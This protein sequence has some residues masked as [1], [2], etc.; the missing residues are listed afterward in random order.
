MKTRLKLYLVLVLIIPVVH[1]ESFT[2]MTFNAQNLFDTLDDEGKDD[3]AY[4]PL[5]LKQ[6]EEHQRSCSNINV[7]A[8]RNECF[9][10]DWNEET[11]DA[12]LNILLNNIITYNDGGA[13]VIALQEIENKNILKQLFDLLKPYGYTE[14]ELLESTDKRGVD[15]A[16]ISRYEL[17]NPS[18]HYVKFSPKFATYDTRPIFKITAS[19]NKKEIVI[20]NLHFPSNF[21]DLQMRIESFNLLNDL[22]AKNNEPSIALGDFNLS[23]KDDTKFNIYSNQQD[24]WYVSHLEGCKGCK[25]THYYSYDKTWSFLD[26]IFVSRDRGITFN[27]KSIQLHKTESNSYAD[28]G[29][30]I[31]FNAKAK[32]GVS[33]H[34]AVVAEIKL[35]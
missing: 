14:Y 8:W 35:N 25:G 23:S 6:N 22:L 12:K 21:N 28:S 20:Y 26:A 2:I 16:F 15:T 18:L 13:D 5:K 9:F 10:L 29:R 32:K 3:K 7:K 27:N 4:L 31:R 17:S 1:A 24:V 34:F 11:K 19:I 33:D 30:P